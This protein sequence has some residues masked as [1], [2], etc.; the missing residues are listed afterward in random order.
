MSDTAGLIAEMARA[1]ADFLAALSPSQR[2]RASLPFADEGERRTWYYFPRMRGGLPLG[3]MASRLQQ[4]LALRLVRSGLSEAGFNAA[5][6]IIGLDNLLDSRE[7]FLQRPYPYGAPDSRFRDPLMYFVTVFGSPFDDG[8]WGWRFEGH[9]VCVN[10]TIRDGAVSATPL[11][12]GA[13][14]ADSPLPGGKELRP[15]GGEEDAARALLAALR[16]D[17]RAQ[18]VIAPA[19]PLD[20]VQSN[21]PRVEDGALPIPLNAQMGQTDGSAWERRRQLFGLT[22]QV[23]ERLRFTT[24]PKGLAGA[25]MDAAQHAALARLLDVYVGRLP[26]PLAA[27]RSKLVAPED[28]SFA[29]AGAVERGGFHYYRLQADRLL[30]EYENAALGGNDIPNHI[31]AVL[32]DP[33][34]D[35]G[36]VLAEHR[37]AAHAR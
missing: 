5:S 32:R 7:G 21:R 25:A 9:H 34:G 2:K 22:P 18:A 19:A 15:L 36:D 8:A 28:V 11:F 35:F 30:I 4:Q 12:F 23:E 24:E 6:T 20:V 1:A 26:E 3:Q 14:P 29:W 16:P 17:Q 27:Q 10:Y 33:A 13:D 37:A 31:H